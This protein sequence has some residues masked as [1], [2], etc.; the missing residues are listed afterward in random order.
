MGGLLS[1]PVKSYPNLFG[2]N[3]PFGGATGVQWLMKYPYALPMLV[4]CILLTLCAVLVAVG[5]EEVCLLKSG[6][7]DSC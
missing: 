2:P 1:D 6:S 5:L 4:N 3:S 7:T